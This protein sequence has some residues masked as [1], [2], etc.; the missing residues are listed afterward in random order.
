[1]SEISEKMRKNLEMMKVS[2]QKLTTS[3]ILTLTG[4]VLG[5]KPEF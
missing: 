2:F 3:G 4:G 1:M 5:G